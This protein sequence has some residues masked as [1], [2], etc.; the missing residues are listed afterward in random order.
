MGYYLCDGIYPPWATLISGVAGVVS[1]KQRLFTVKQ[2]EY[3]KDIERCFDV[4]QGQYAIIKGP[5]RM[6]DQEDLRYIVDCVVILHNMAIKF[7][8][9]LQRLAGTDYEAS[10]R[11]HKFGSWYCNQVFVC[12]LSLLVQTGMCISRIIM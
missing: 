12:L 9:N 2:A 6:W 5:T 8:S 3:Q 11:R 7:E 1:N 10:T 4:L